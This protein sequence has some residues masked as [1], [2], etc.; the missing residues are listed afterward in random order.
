MRDAVTDSMNDDA[1]AVKIGMFD[2]RPRAQGPSP[3]KRRLWRW[4]EVSRGMDSSD[5]AM[6]VAPVTHCAALGD[7]GSGRLQ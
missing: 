1:A 4:L 2:A 7:G 3:L 6:T 5:K